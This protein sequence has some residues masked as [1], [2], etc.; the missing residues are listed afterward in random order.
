MQQRN[1]DLLLGVFLSVDPATANERPVGSSIATRHISWQSVGK[2]CEGRRHKSI[3]IATTACQ[4]S[5]CNQ[6]Q[7]NPMA[8]NQSMNWSCVRH[9]N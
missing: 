9:G 7:R 8:S 2:R 1:M 4:C 6:Y 5:R 3:L